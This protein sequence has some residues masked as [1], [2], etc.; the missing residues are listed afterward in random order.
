[1]LDC[2]LLPHCIHLAGLLQRP[3]PRSISLAAPKAINDSISG[4]KYGEH[5][6]QQHAAFVGNT[7][8]FSICQ[9]PLLDAL[10]SFHLALPLRRLNR[11]HLVLALLLL[12]LLQAPTTAGTRCGTR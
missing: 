12:L 7:F 3:K 11:F 2:P 9:V 10:F 5:A 4:S 8:T 1:M 6:M